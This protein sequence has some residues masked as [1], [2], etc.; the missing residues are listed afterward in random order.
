[1]FGE[2]ILSLDKSHELWDRK[3][4]DNHFRHTV[5]GVFPIFILDSKRVLQ[6]LS[7]E[8]LFIF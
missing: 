6:G 5:D 2:K 1:M 8:V 3:L 7:N 4:H